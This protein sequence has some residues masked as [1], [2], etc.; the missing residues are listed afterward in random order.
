MRF[1]YNF[2]D[3]NTFWKW[4]SI[5]N[6]L[7]KKKHI[8][9]IPLNRAKPNINRWINLDYQAKRQMI[10]RKTYTIT[11]I[12]FWID[13][14]IYRRIVFTKFMYTFL[15]QLRHTM[16]SCQSRSNPRMQLYTLLCWII[17]QDGKITRIKRKKIDKRKQ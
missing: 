13:L 5:F 9:K 12:H 10:K 14:N 15:N 17:T 1:R 2:Y 7:T 4:S 8:H 16:S 11:Q 3:A 6:G